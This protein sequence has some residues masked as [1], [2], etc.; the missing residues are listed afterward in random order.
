M[1]D[2]PEKILLVFALPKI[3]KQGSER[4]WTT[5]LWIC[6]RMLYHWATLPEANN[7]DLPKWL[8]QNNAPCFVY[9]N[10]KIL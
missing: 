7:F 1:F 5:E 8:V 2:F 4:N 10:R 6:S 3:F 9:K